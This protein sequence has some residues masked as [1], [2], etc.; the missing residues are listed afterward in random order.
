[1]TKTRL[2]FTTDSTLEEMFSRYCHGEG[3]SKAGLLRR[4]LSDYIFK[5]QREFIKYSDKSMADIEKICQR[6][7]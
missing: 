2:I 3:Y 1:M 7:T 5:H 6:N 4:I